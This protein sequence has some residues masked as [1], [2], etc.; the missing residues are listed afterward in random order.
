MSVVHVNSISGITSITSPSSS[1]VLTLHTS[2]NAER[3][4]IDSNGKLLVGGTSTD[5]SG[6]ISIVKNTTEVLADNEPLYNNASPAFLTVY[7]TNNTGSGEEAG[8]NIVPAGNANGAISIYGKKTG[9][10]AGDLIFRFRSGASTSAERLRI[11]S[12]GKVGINESN[13]ATTLELSAGT[14]KNLNVWSSGAYATGIT[15]GSAN[16]A[17]S[18]YTP[19]EFRGSE[20]YFHNGTA[21]KLRITSAGK[22]GI[23]TE[24]PVGNLE[25]RDTKANLIVA[26]DGLTVKNNSDIAA[27][28]DLIQLGAGGA[29]ASYSTAT[30]TADTQFIHNAYRH[31]GNNWK[32]RYADTAARLRVNSPARTWVFESAAS[33]SADGD[34]TWAEQL[35]IKSDG[36]VG[37]GTNNVLSRL[38]V[39]DTS[40]TV[41]PFSSAVADTYSYT[42]YPHELVIDND[43]RGTEGSFAGI[44]FNAGADTDGSKVSTARISAIDTGSYKADLVFSNRGAGGSS[45][46]ENLRITSDGKVG[47]N[48]TDPKSQLHLYGPADLRMGSLY[49]GVAML[50]LQVEY[51]S[52]YT[53]TH[54]IFEITDQA[55]YSFEG[56]HIVHGSGGSSYGIECTVVRMLASRE[57]GA[58]DSGDTW[59]NGTVKYNND[60]WGHDQVGLNPGAGAFSFAYDDAATTTTSNQKIAFSASGQ[61]VGVWAK[62]NGVFTWGTTSTNGRVKIKDKDGNVLWDSNP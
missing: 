58:T 19:I 44:Y 9:S 41:W 47:I 51:A 20:F 11:T 30:A 22:V 46:K 31:S 23:G 33:G 39:A 57:A 6:L 61:G 13:P 26:K 62:L 40:T 3:L 21:E 43:V 35:R 45:H 27:S 5:A 16:D 28:Y 49:G 60:S 54:F 2:N 53:G 52:G 14:N 48:V 59:R 34:I 10:Y 17:F 4:R 50:A 25:V 32:Y 8:I 29:L 7:N 1:D 55:S 12:D 56:S 38:H 37:I 42:P 24:I 36:K 18:A 15:I